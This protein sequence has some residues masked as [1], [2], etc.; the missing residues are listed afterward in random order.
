MKREAVIQA[1]ILIAVT[2]LPGAMFERMNTGA[3]RTPD[4]RLVRF[5]TPGGPDIRGTLNGQAV[6]IEC[7]TVK[8]R[9]RPDQLRWRDCF[10]RAGGCYIIGKD[11]QDVIHALEA[12]IRKE[13]AYVSS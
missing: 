7:K 8:G 6:A 5:G 3:A 4:G 1:E 13:A 10:E 9:L 11:A 12:L 2:A